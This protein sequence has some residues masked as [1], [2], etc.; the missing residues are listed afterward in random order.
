M[1]VNFDKIYEIINN[2]IAF[3]NAVHGKEVYQN[4]FLKVSHNI[5]LVMLTWLLSICCKNV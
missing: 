1:V 4:L 5:S 3:E 2:V